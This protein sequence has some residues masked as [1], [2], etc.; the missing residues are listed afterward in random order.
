M[1]AKALNIEDMD[2]VKQLMELM[3]QQNM[4]E[5]SQ[6]FVEVLRYVAGMQLQIGAMV[7]EL[8]GVRE[9][10]AN[11]QES[12]PNPAKSS[13]VEKLIQLEGKVTQLS[14]RLSQIK[15][16]L[17]ETAAQA[18][19]AFK[20]KGVQAMNQVIQNGISAVKKPLENF[21]EKLS[22]VLIDSEKTANQID[23]IGDEL[24]QIGNSVANVGRLISGKGTKDVSDEKQGVALTRVI[25]MPIKRRITG[26][27]KKLVR[28]DQIFDKLDKVSAKF[29]PNKSQDKSERVSVKEKLSQMK[30]K[31]A[32]QNKQP[33]KQKAKSQE[34]SL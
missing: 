1:E 7:G 22:E 24:K 16:R 34:E 17:V 8:Q 20:E 26:L 2:I 11:M 9:Q 15:D 25:N 5:Q 18:V 19:N 29:E 6:D 32:Q 14:E 12:E 4:K 33:E 23:S 3:E 21:R 28:I 13:L 27:R 10:L 31:S 30:T